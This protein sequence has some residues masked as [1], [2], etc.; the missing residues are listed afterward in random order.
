[1]TAFKPLVRLR[2]EN[3][4]PSVIQPD[5][6]HQDSH[7]VPEVDEAKHGHRGGAVRRQIHFERTLGMAQMQLQGQRRH[8]QKRERGQQREPIGRLDGFNAED[9]LERREDEGAGDQ[10]VING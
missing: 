7:Q 6:Q 3:D 8:Q 5:F 1:M 4:V 9:T 2:E 10:A